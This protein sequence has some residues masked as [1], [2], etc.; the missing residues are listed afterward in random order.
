MTIGNIWN[1]PS[2]DHQLSCTV[3]L[4][5][6]LPWTIIHFEHVQ[7]LRDGWWQ[8][9]PFEEV[10]VGEMSSQTINDSSAP[11]DVWMK[12]HSVD[13]PLQIPIII[14][15]L[16]IYLFI[17]LFICLFVCLFISLPGRGGGKTFQNPE[18][19]S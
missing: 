15:F 3:M 13:I 9:F 1:A 10:V 12:V 7:S 5:H 8:V 6:R 4:H 18:K 14:Y 19:N 17:Y 11:F 2:F 16:F